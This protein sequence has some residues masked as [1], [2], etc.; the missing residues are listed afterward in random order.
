MST[1]KCT[2]CNKEFKVGFVDATK[3]VGM[4]GIQ[5]SVFKPFKTF[6]IW[7]FQT[8]LVSNCPSC[9]KNTKLLV[10]ASKTTK[11]V[12]VSLILS[13][14]V[15]L[16]I[17]IYYGH[18]KQEVLNI[19]ECNA[20]AES[21]GC[22][23][24]SS[25]EC[26][27]EN[28]QC[29]VQLGIKNQDMRICDLLNGDNKDSCYLGVGVNSKNSLICDKITN[30]TY[31]NPCYREVAISILNPSLCT[32]I[33]NI[34]NEEKDGCYTQVAL[35]TENPSLCLQVDNPTTKDIC[36]GN[37]A[38]VKGDVSICDNVKNSDW[39]ILC[40]SAVNRNTSKCGSIQNADI[41][42]ICQD[43]DK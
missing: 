38:N 39:K 18:T 30:A 15:G 42:N 19:S 8:S 27:N 12:T 14:I 33:S 20:L 7:P 35:K 1:L 23:N 40:I 34:P 28:N 21:H 25:T 26:L 32:K 37:I 43:V 4:S 6:A 16:G 10:I 24:N 17:F 22:Q 29:L 41:K 5:W 13:V 3:T 2:E 36:Y 11:I 31:K 9:G